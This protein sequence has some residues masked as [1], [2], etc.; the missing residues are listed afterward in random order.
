MKKNFLLIILAL[1]PIVAC[2]DDS[3]F[4][5]YEKKG[6]GY[7]ENVWWTW[8]E[9]THTL[10]ISGSGEM[11]WFAGGMEDDMTPNS[12][13][14]EDYKESIQTLIVESGVTA[15]GGFHNFTNLTSVSLPNT[16]ERFH[17]FAFWGCGFSSISIPNSVKTIETDA[18]AE[19]SNLL[20]IIIPSNVEKIGKA[21]LRDCSSLESIKVESG[22]TVYDSRNNC[23]AIIVKD[24]Y[25]WGYSALLAGCKNTIIPDGV[26]MIEEFAFAGC[27]GL[28]SLKIP[29]SVTNLRSDMLAGCIN[30]TALYLY[31]SQMPSAI[32]EG[33]GGTGRQT[34]TLGYIQ[35]AI[36]YVPSV[37]LDS[38]KSSAWASKVKAIMSIES[39]SD[40]K[41]ATPTIKV[42]NGILKFE[43]ATEGVDFHYT[44]KLKTPEYFISSKEGEELYYSYSGTYNKTN[45]SGINDVVLP[46]ATITVYASKS[47]YSLSDE[48]TLAVKLSNGKFGDL[49]G[50]GVVNVADHVELS[51]II[52]DT[53]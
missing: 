22:N 40:P 7:E 37:L 48:A 18:F 10:T 15:V 8:V 33:F 9:S 12:T 5:G 44:I 51:K 31:C 52:M 20:S 34:Y 13:P 35:N 29:Q 30:L 3:G 49:T 24:Y 45:D 28:T 41:C 19:C 47:G 14:W 38:Y 43:C 39:A 2:A 23:N 27:I 32:L 36:L 50:D 17:H 42:E 4:C 53:K 25:G 21:V 16:I 1:V 26:T 11:N 46:N 6:G